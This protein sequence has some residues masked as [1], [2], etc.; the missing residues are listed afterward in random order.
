MVPVV[1][2]T[3]FLG[4]GKTSLL[5]RML[6]RRAE[7]AGRMAIV[8][9][10]FGD[11]GIDGDLLPKGMSRQVELPGGCICCVLNEDLD[12][13]LLGLLDSEPEL[14][15]V[16]IETTGVA[17]PAPITWSLER[18]PLSSRVRLAA[19][20]TVVDG[21]HH[22]AHRTLTHAVDL[23]VEYADLL[24]LSKLD[25]L[26]G[27]EPPDALVSRLREA[28]AHAPLLVSPP[29]RMADVIWEALNDP[30]Q[31]S[32][33]H[34]GR[35]REPTAHRGLA[36][37]AAHPTHGAIHS[38]GTEFDTISLTIEHTLDFEEL[39]TSLEEL[40]ANYVRIKGIARVVDASTGT[41]EPHFV[42]FHRVGARVSRE[43]L[44]HPAPTRMVAIGP[45]ID[46][47]R[48]AACLDAAVVI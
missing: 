46:R 8:V 14:V 40:P 7:D 4:S 5:N 20:V 16:V 23:Q 17:E 29:E 41:S 24:V 36:A 43:P 34:P 12:K 1:L 19:V 25:L 9:N 39:A 48:L 28:N 18:E 21:I 10:E 35:E 2:L 47:A 30:R 22:E 33:R 45:N 15:L 26:E 27:G 3:G 13:T 32:L 38:H 44:A 37:H 31:A 6:D 42:A 11:V